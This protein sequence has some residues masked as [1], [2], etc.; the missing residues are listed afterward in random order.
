MENNEEFMTL[1]KQEL[2]KR[3]IIDKNFDKE[4]FLDYCMSVKENGDDLHNW[5]FEELNQVIL[6]FVKKI[7]EEKNVNE[8][9]QKK[10][11]EIKIEI[12][13]M[14]LCVK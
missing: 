12:E 14:K 2:L 4:R 8:N 1:K 9:N 3:E 13:R 5:T 6:D 11:E 10:P 7:Y